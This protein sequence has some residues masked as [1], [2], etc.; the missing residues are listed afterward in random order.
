MKFHWLTLAGVAFGGAL[1]AVC[2]YLVAETAKSWFGESFPVGTLIVNLVGCFLLGLIVGASRE[3]LPQFAH[4]IIAIGFLG[5]L[6]TFSTF[7]VETVKMF[8]AGN[9][10]FGFG[11]VAIQIVAGLLA[12]WGGMGIARAFQ[13]AAAG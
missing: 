3:S 12:A 13:G 1:G 7:G 9:W 8:E 11:N 5:A 2:R 10:S 6:T 4:P